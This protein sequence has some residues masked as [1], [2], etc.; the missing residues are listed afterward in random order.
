MVNHG[1][2]RSGGLDVSAR[3]GALLGAFV[4]GMSYQPNLLSRSTRDQALITGVATATAFEWGTAMHSFLRSTADRLPDGGGSAAR[5]VTTGAI[6]D[7]SALAAG[8]ALNAAARPREDEPARRALVR[9]A[10][11]KRRLDEP[12]RF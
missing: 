12:P 1:R 6:V 3:A 4:T 8:L 5:R 2:V 11:L 9:L 7:A 10:E